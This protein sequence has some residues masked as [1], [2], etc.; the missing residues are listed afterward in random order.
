MYRRH[1][2]EVE[3]ITLWI[4][5]GMAILSKDPDT[6]KAELQIAAAGPLAS[7]EASVRQAVEAALAVTDLDEVGT[8][9]PLLDWCSMRHETQYTRLFRS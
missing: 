5:G 3:T 6:A 1:G 8:A 4:L 7:L 9:T 2:L